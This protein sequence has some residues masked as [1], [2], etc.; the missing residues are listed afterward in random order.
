MTSRGSRNSRRLSWLLRHGAGEAGLE[1]DIAGWAALDDVVPIAN[2][3]RAEVLRAVEENDKGRLQ[4]DG[5]RIRACQGHSVHNMPVT[6]SGLEA[7]WE[8]IEP[9]GS[10]W[11]GTALAALAGIGRDGITAG[12]RTH[13]HLAQSPTSRVGKRAHVD[14]L[15]QVSPHRVRASG[16]EI[17]R[18]PNGVVLVE[19]VPADCIIDA[20]PQGVARA[21]VLGVCQAAGIS[22]RA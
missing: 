12:S 18:A 5:D 11:H 15:L 13:V 22:C 17:F 19:H 4:L 6:R 7:T 16:F 9:T 8:R 1:M 10:L 3:T 20:V 2:L 14:V 21:L